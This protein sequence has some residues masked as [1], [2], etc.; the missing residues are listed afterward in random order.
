M[1]YS[2]Q[3]IKLDIIFPKSLPVKN[4]YNSKSINCFSIVNTFLLH[5]LSKIKV[6]SILKV[7]TLVFGCRHEK[8]SC[9]KLSFD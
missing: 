3:T 1:N 8:D 4:Q 9:D 2:S 7:K 6:N 5:F